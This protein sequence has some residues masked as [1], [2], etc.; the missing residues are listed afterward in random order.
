MKK[1]SS[2]YWPVAL[3]LLFIW[4]ALLL[5]FHPRPLI[6]FPNHDMFETTAYTD[7]DKRGNSEIIDLKKSPH[8]IEFSFI[9]KDRLRF[10]YC[11]LVFYFTPSPYID[12]SGYD[13]LVLRLKADNTKW[14]E[15]RREEY[16]PGITKPGVADIFKPLITEIPVSADWRDYSI[17]FSV[18]RTPSW[19]M[20]E[21]NLTDQ[22][23]MAS[24]PEY[25]STIGFQNSEAGAFNKKITLYIESIRLEKNPFTAVIIT[26]I[27]AALLT[28][29]GVIL[30]FMQRRPAS[31]MQV[32]SL[33]LKNYTAEEEAR[34]IEYLGN[35]YFEPD[36]SLGTVNQ[37]TGIPLQKITKTVRKASGM[38]FKKYINVLRM[39]EA[40]RQLTQTDRPVTE[41]AMILGYNNTTHFNR[42]FKEMEAVSPTDY[43]KANRKM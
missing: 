39:A 19:F 18:M 2:Y 37:D 15:V 5:I 38:P 27:L 29:A 33:G 26:V 36:I 23:I 41:I 21:H 30:G 12:A 9:L 24:R 8:R 34:V 11:G 25:F 10:P 35:H 28:A 32:K 22:S 31:V 1:L 17:P 7:S 43:R 13:T 6:V 42:V 20:D 4:T 3:A 16:I 14:V 40:K